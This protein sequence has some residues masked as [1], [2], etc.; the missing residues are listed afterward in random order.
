M[1]TVRIVPCTIRTVHTD[2]LLVAHNSLVDSCEIYIEIP[3][4]IKGRSVSG[5][6]ERLLEFQQ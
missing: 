3:V 1:C 6:D 4:F 2:W 5:V